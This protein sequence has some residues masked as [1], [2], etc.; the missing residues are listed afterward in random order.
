MRG[1]IF[2][3]RC[4]WSLQLRRGIGRSRTPSRLRRP[5]AGSNSNAR[6]SAGSTS[7]D[8]HVAPSASRDDSRT[9][10]TMLK[11]SIP[12]PATRKDLDP[13]TMTTQKSDIQQRKVAPSFAW[14][15]IPKAR[16]FSSTASAGTPSFAS[17]PASPVV[18][19]LQ[20]LR[21]ASCMI[22]SV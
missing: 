1:Y 17:T 6:D 5:S 22:G 8:Q 3:H 4:W 12:M 21:Q 16:T 13:M 2:Q 14:S 18:H 11:V 10:S 7:F 20:L 19:P 15:C 9:S